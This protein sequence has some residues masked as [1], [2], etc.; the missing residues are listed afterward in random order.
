M[1][2]PTFLIFTFVSTLKNQICITI[3]STKL[4]PNTSTHP[5][6]FCWVLKR[7]Y[8]RL[9]ILQSTYDGSSTFGSNSMNKIDRNC[10]FTCQNC[11]K[12]LEKYSFADLGRFWK[13][14][15]QLSSI[16]FHAILLK[17]R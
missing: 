9:F 2:P 3:T 6:P 8:R 15:S 16:F 17:S 1:T 5:N 10:V 13:V 14:I 7:F 12:E 4:K 11:N